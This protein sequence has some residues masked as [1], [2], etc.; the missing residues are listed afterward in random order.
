MNCV[1]PPARHQRGSSKKTQRTY[2]V[3]L[4]WPRPPQPV[5]LSSAVKR[6][7]ENF[8]AISRRPEGR[9][10]RQ[11]GGPSGTPPDGPCRTVPTPVGWR[12]K[13]KTSGPHSTRKFQGRSVIRQ[14]NPRDGP[15]RANGGRQKLARSANKRRAN[16]PYQIPPLRP[17]GKLPVPPMHAKPIGA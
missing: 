12:E 6:P 13:R 3:R 2:P 17:H 4:R 9:S 1:V 11:L 15:H 8:C 10:R 7:C 16:A 14:E 5:Q